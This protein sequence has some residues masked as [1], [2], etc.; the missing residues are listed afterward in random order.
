[1]LAVLVLDVTSV[2]RPL[3]I[4]IIRI[5]ALRGTARTKLRACATLVD[6]FDFLKIEIQTIA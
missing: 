3:I 1:M 2:K 5:A 4:M 6:N